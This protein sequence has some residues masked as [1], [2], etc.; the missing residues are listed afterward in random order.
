MHFETCF[1]DSMI[2]FPIGQMQK[3]VV[4]TMP[5]MAATVL[6]PGLHPK[7]L[8]LGL[9]AERQVRDMSNAFVRCCQVRLLAVL[10]LFLTATLLDVSS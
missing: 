2:G 1:D 5:I 10:P 3:L 6:M 4:G 9:V 7:A 8:N